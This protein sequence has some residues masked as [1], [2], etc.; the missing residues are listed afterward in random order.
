VRS[1]KIIARDCKHQ[2]TSEEIVDRLG[3]LKILDNADAVYYHFFREDMISD[4]KLEYVYLINNWNLD[5]YRSS[6]HKKVTL[7]LLGNYA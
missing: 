2:E 5:N 4:S 3:Q 6:N 1:P 7:L